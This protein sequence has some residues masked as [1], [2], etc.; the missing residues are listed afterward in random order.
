MGTIWVRGH[1]GWQ[2]QQRATT[3]LV[4]F[5]A[6]FSLVAVLFSMLL[7]ADPAPALKLLGV[8]VIAAVAVGVWL[9]AAHIR[10]PRSRIA[11]AAVDGREVVFAGVPG[12]IRPLRAFAFVGAVILAGCAWSVFTVPADAV[13]MRM[14]LGVLVI[15]LT[16]LIAGVRFWFRPPTAHRL[17]LRPDGLELRIP[18]NHAS[19]SWEDISGASLQG[20][21][22][23]LRTATARPSSWAATDLASDP[24]IL[25]E[26]VTFYASN[27]Q[28]R[29]EIGPTTLARLRRGDFPGV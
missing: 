20:N 26:L 11:R 14:L 5:A 25:A 28:A 29:A 15:G 6:V 2:G 24:V 16:L 10:V 21:R 8:G 23:M 3:G 12:I 7:F 13:R 19:L 27:P 22:V 18:R 17:T 9:L 4:V 1:A